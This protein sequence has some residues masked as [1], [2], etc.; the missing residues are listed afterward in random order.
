MAV[1]SKVKG[2]I[3]ASEALSSRNQLIGSNRSR[4]MDLWPLLNLVP[5]EIRM[6]IS[7]V[8]TFGQFGTELLFTTLDDKTYGI[9][10][11]TSGCL[12]VGDNINSLEPR[13]VESFNGKKI[14][15]M[16]SGCGP[17]VLV[18]TE[19]GDV[20]TWGHNSY[21][22]LGNGGTAPGLIPSPL[23]RHFCKKAIQVACGS[24]HS[25]VLT[26]D[27]E[28]WAWGYNNC[29][30]VGSGSTSNQGAPRKVTACIGNKKIINIGCGQTASIAVTDGGEVY[31]W[32][33]NGNGQLGVGNNVNQTNP[34]RIAALQG[35]V[36]QQVICGYAH[37]LALTDDGVVFGW[38]A[39]SYGQLGSGNKAN[40]VTPLQVASNM[41]RVVTIAASHYSHCSAAQNQ[42]GQVWMW[43]QLR[44]QPT[45]E[46][47]LTSFTNLNAVFAHFSGPPISWRPMVVCS[48]AEPSVHQSVS[49]AF[50]DEATSDLKI[51]S[52][53]KVIYVH[54]AL[55]KI[56]CDYFRR[57]F[58]SHW[59]EN[60][61]DTVEINGYSY[62]V[63]YSFLQWL[64][65]DHVE[66]P[67]E[68]AIG[69]LDLATSYCENGLKFQCQRLIKEGINEENAALLYAAAIK[70]QAQDLLDFCFQFCL[71]H[72]T[73]VV[74]TDSFRILDKEMMLNFILQA[75]AKG[76]FKR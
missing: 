62:S 7:R 57:M 72:M 12:G 30:Q 59:G 55:L 21:M 18:L 67:P 68:D 61:Q 41:G 36:I 64:Y 66:L 47:K 27:G 38:G 42:N 17:H 71:N 40:T 19:D 11:N 48:E 29:G 60:N 75:A 49:A 26:V 50:N 37:T 25:M 54:K 52:E 3:V 58:Q 53:G 76:A 74:Q 32:G 1:S 46:P 10:M 65:T 4:D 14:V 28:V 16:S 13:C 35:V 9:G 33:Y 8:Y 56:R 15:G 70:Y 51:V 45:A 39:N 63:V 24:H 73:R 23:S 31:S 20:F 34:C 69:L 6:K 43:G 2:D 22:Q 5:N 44:Q